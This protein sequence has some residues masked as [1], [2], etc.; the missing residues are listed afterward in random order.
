MKM[1]ISCI[2]ITSLFFFI[3]SVA[4]KKKK[5]QYLSGLLSNQISC[6]IIIEFDPMVVVLL[7]KHA[8]HQHIEYL[9]FRAC[10]GHLRM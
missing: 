9:I 10:N 6:L 4:K 3:C 5:K 7:N 1:K 8:A 2:Y